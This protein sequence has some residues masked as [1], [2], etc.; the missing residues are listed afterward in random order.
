M[1]TATK[2]PSTD[3]ILRVTGGSRDGELI[4]VSTPKCYLGMESTNDAISKDP[5]CVIFRGR[6]GAVIR[7]YAKQVMF[8]DSAASLHWLRKGDTIQFPNAMKIEVVQL[9]NL[10]S[11]SPTSSPAGAAQGT[12]LTTGQR[13]DARLVVLESELQSIQLQNEQTVTRFDQ[14]DSRLSMLTEKM[15]MLINLSL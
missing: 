4:S 11:T 5:Q 9:G 14:L 1:T 13:D 15:T 8:N 7:S 10:K 2:A 12:S 3:L 6:E